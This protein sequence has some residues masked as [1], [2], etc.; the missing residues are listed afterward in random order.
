MYMDELIIESEAYFS[1]KDDLV[2]VLLVCIEED[3]KVIQ[4]A[5]GTG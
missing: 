2:T 4:L 3:T 5:R 1:L